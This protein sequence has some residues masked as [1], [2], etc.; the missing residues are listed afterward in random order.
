[1]S[2]QG[3]IV[4]D[5]PKLDYSPRTTHNEILK[6][7]FGDLIDDHV[8]N[9]SWKSVYQLEKPDELSAILGHS[10]LVV[11]NILDDI[12]QEGAQ[13]LYN[14]YID[15]KQAD[16][17]VLFSLGLFEKSYQN[18]FRQHDG[19]TKAPGVDGITEDQ[20]P[21]TACQENW[22]RQALNVRPKQIQLDDGQN[23]AQ[24]QGENLNERPSLQSIQSIQ[25]SKMK[26]NINKDEN[27]IQQEEQQITRSKRQKKT[28][29]KLIDC[30]KERDFDVEEES[31]RVAKEREIQNK[32]D[33]QLLQQQREQQQKDQQIKL[34]QMNPSQKSSYTYD[35]DGI[36]LLQPAQKTDKFSPVM[37]QVDH[38]CP[39][40]PVQVESQQEFLNEPQQQQLRI[41]NGDL[42]PM[43]NSKQQ[44][45][46]PKKSKFREDFDIPSFSQTLIKQQQ[47]MEPKQVL[48]Y[49]Q[50][51]SGVTLVSGKV[52]KVG[53]V[54]KNINVFENSDLLQKP[55]GKLQMSRHDYLNITRQGNL[56]RNDKS[57]TKDVSK[58]KRSYMKLPE[59][60]EEED[61]N[62]SNQVGKTV[63]NDISKTIIKEKKVEKNKGFILP[64]SNGD[65]SFFNSFKQ[66]ILEDIEKEQIQKQRDQLGNM[67]NKAKNNNN[68]TQLYKDL[69]KSNISQINN[70]SQ[71]SALDSFNLNLIKKNPDFSSKNNN[72]SVSLPRLKLNKSTDFDVEL[73]VGNLSKYPR[74]R[75]NNYRQKMLTLKSQKSEFKSVHNQD[76]EEPD[77]I[78]S[79]LYP[80][81]QK[82]MKFYDH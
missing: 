33:Q 5:I 12:I 69:N 71:S 16:R 14:K 15:N 78:L 36:I 11:Q 40:K 67:I 46:Q 63:L 31:I 75:I 38:K 29:F 2:Q 76:L 49:F 44:Q 30:R 35:Y 72:N 42:S 53:A 80:K 54:N 21:Q 45:S 34:K 65:L 26:Q 57:Y 39:Q 59:N 51:K 9:A 50:M 22:K 17:A 52:V 77:M 43:M 20:E 48:D 74:N 8:N 68:S 60:D 37:M 62:L 24:S 55:Q 81:S 7:E 3:E 47:Q 18:Q 41:N 70:N 64:G 79:K 73:S 13:I 32:L 56:S 82:N 19:D 61:A 1:M 25:K 27:K 10:V 4:L 6:E 28:E 23:E 58:K 66:D